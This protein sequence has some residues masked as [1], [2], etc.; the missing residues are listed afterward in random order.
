MHLCLITAHFPIIFYHFICSERNSQRWISVSNI[1]FFVLFLSCILLKIFY[2]TLFLFL[3]QVVNYFIF[4][5]FFLFPLLVLCVNPIII[6]YY[7]LSEVVVFFFSFFFM[8]IIVQ[9]CRQWIISA[10][11]YLKKSSLPFWKKLFTGKQF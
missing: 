11:I 6:L 4:T 8:V 5:L 1:P 3:L 10:F 7:T 9:V 2:K